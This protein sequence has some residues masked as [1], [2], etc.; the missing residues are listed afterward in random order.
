VVGLPA[1]V[2]IVDDE[3]GNTF[4]QAN[5]MALLRCRPRSSASRNQQV[6]SS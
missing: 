3:L 2:G 4:V 5:G 6:P 1:A